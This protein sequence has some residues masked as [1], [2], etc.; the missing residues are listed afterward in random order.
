MET[1]EHLNEFTVEN[2]RD[3]LRALAPALII[4]VVDR[5]ITAKLEYFAVYLQ[6]EGEAIYGPGLGWNVRGMGPSEWDVNDPDEAVR[7][8]SA[9]KPEHIKTAVDWL[10]ERA[11][12]EIR[13]SSE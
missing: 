8:F 4:D 11:Y 3:H 6:V 13:A 9:S 10:A 1:P 5:T 7:R 12:Q 2:M